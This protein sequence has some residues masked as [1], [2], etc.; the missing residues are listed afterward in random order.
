MTATAGRAALAASPDELSPSP[1]GADGGA[2][3]KR[4]AARSCWARWRCS[5]S[6]S[7]SGTSLHYVVMSE[8]RRFLVPPPHRVVDKSS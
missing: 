4:S 2:G 6:S 8:T 7:A 5:P 3:R 1:A